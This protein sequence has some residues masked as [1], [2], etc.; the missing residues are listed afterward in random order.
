LERAAM[1]GTGIKELAMMLQHPVAEFVST[2]ADQKKYSVLEGQVTWGRTKATYVFNTDTA[3][4]RSHAKV[5]HRG[6]D[7]FIED[8]GST[9]GTFIKVKEK[10][11]VPDGAVLSIANQLFKIVREQSAIA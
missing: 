8:T 7:F 3:M 1:M 2:A 5:Y 10:T 4:S 11:P 9:N 6:E